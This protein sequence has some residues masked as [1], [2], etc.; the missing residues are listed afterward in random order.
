MHMRICLLQHREALSE[1]RRYALWNVVYDNGKQQ[2]C[3][4][5]KTRKP[6]AWW[7]FP[8]LAGG[9]RKSRSRSSGLC[10]DIF[11]QQRCESGM[12][13]KCEVRAWFE[14]A[15]TT[16]SGRELLI[17]P[18]WPRKQFN[19]AMEH[20]VRSQSDPF[21]KRIPSQILLSTIRGI[22]QCTCL[23]LRLRSKWAAHYLCSTVY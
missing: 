13:H 2:I 23:E 17:W 6:C 10:K 12:D 1:E 8:Q 21:R 4:Y 16:H 5:E 15:G 20:L 7:M 18:K 22:L 14:Y 9:T 19:L 3:F 11:G